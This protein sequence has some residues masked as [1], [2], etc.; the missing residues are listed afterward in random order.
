MLRWWYSPRWRGLA[1]QLFTVGALVLFV[2]WITDNTAHNLAQQGK[3]AGFGFLDNTA[4][5]AINFHLIPYTETDTLARVFWVGALNT[6]LIA[7]LGI[8]FATVIGFVV[9]VSQLSK[10]PL[11]RALAVGYVELF[12]NIPLLLQIFF[13]YFIVL[14]PLP[15]PKNSFVF[16]DSLFVNNRGL[17]LPE[18]LAQAGFGWVWLALAAAAVFAA[19][20]AWWAR[21]RQRLTGATFPVLLTA[22][23]ALVAAPTLA[24]FAAGAPIDLEYPRLSGFNIA[25]DTGMWL[26]PE[27]ISLLFA[28]SVYTASFIAENVRA[29][30]LAVQG[31]QTE[32][33]LSLGLSRALALRLVIIPQALRVIVPPLTNQ[34]LNITKNSSLAVAIAYPEVVSVFAG[35]AL[36]ITGQ[37]IEILFITM[38]FY[39]SISLLIAA[40]MSRYNRRNQLQSRAAAR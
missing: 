38:M 2:L 39:L 8:V 11:V 37:E 15:A 26:P 35:I 13:W 32:A 12:R 27:F 30:I 17:Y 34:Y 28:L 20:L 6:L 40:V 3:A 4:G 23:V 24:F 1:Y 31:G 21:R 36:N 33:A 5:F 7:L 19:L 22:L 25:K 16:F 10:N 29:G 14:R 18:P 9:G